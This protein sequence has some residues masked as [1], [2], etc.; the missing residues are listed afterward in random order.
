MAD[1]PA[2]VRAFKDFAKSIP[3]ADDLPSM[4]KEF[5][6]ENDRA[7]GILFATWVDIA[8]RGSIESIFRPDLSSELLKRLFD[9]EGPMGSFGSRI[10]VGYALSIFGKKTQHDLDL[11]RLIRNEFAHCR[12]PLAFEIKQVSDVCAN[13]QLPETEQSRKPLILNQLPNQEKWAKIW[14]DRSHP[15]MRFVTTCNTIANG[16]LVFATRGDRS[17]RSSELP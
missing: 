4:E 3:S 10:N 7:C 16:L 15:T 14:D 13:F 9:F 8:L 2:Y 17:V 6:G 5:L 12:L 11:V 1:E